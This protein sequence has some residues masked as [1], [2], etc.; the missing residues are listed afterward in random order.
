MLRC[1]VGEARTQNRCVMRRSCRGRRAGIL[2]FPAATG[3]AVR[4]WRSD[5]QKRLMKCVG[6]SWVDYDRFTIIAAI[7]V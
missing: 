7:S 3:F 4:A 6:A 2:L 5:E 1:P